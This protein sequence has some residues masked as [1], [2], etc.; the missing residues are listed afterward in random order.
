MIRMF[1]ISN[2]NQAK[3]YYKTALAKADYYIEDQ[4]HEG[5]YHGKIAARLGLENRPVTTKVFNELC[6]NIHPFTG[7]NLTPRTI[8]N[9]RVGYDIS[10]HCPKSVSILHALGNDKRI[11]KAFTESSYETMCEIQ[12][13]M[14]TRVRTQGQYFN[15]AIQ[16]KCYGCH[17][18]MK[19]LALFWGVC[20]TC[21][22]TN[23][24]LL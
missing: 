24:I 20:L 8:E 1:Q 10:F 4:E 12:E 3:E 17:L 11:L 22:Y 2:A 19:P 21:T 14:Q 6:D 15:R 18:F 7:E 5:Y 23:T 13:D 9:R 16:E